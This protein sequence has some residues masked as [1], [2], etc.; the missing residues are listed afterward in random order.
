MVPRRRTVSEREVQPMAIL[1]RELFLT[2]TLPDP[3]PWET[4]RARALQQM[5]AMTAHE[6]RDALARLEELAERI[7]LLV[8]ETRHA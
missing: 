1:A 8:E 5:Q 7:R 6:R 3:P 4:V 2:L